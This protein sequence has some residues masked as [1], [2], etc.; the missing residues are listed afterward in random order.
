MTHHPNQ[1]TFL[2]MMV[3]TG[4]TDDIFLYL[5]NQEKSDL[6]GLRGVYSKTEQ[7]SEYQCHTGFVC[8]LPYREG[9]EGVLEQTEG[10]RKRTPLSGTVYKG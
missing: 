1:L 6:S 8:I 5:V 9:G 3:Q 4:T 10:G 7:S 2:E